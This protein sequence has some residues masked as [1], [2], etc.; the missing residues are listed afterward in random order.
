MIIIMNYTKCFKEIE[1]DNLNSIKNLGKNYNKS[2][3][4]NDSD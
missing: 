4:N 1:K 2:G 3:I